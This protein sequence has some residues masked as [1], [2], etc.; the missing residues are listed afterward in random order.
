MQSPS[1]LRFDA[2]SMISF[3]SLSRPGTGQST[4]AIKEVIT[5]TVTNAI[6]E[7]FDIAVLGFDRFLLLSVILLSLLAF[8]SG[9][10]SVF[11]A[12]S[13]SFLIAGMRCWAG[14][15]LVCRLFLRRAVVHPR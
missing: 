5:S 12:R 6:I 9:W 2:Q 8:S 13:S 14:R 3:R 11:L 7:S 4:T 1:C 10:L 15:F